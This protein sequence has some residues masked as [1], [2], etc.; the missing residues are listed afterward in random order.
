MLISHHVIAVFA[1]L[2]SLIAPPHFLKTLKVFILHQPAIVQVYL[3]AV[4]QPTVPVKGVQVV[5][6]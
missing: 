6:A 5:T 2:L 1:T 4:V 3:G